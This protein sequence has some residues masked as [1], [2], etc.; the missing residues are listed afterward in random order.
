M[1]VAYK[2]D[3]LTYDEICLDIVYNKYQITI[4]EETP[5]LVFILKKNK[6]Y[7]SRHP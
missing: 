4:S 2:I 1:L 5:G 7:I 6:S 3:L